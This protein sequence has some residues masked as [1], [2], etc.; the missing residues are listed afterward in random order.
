MRLREAQKIIRANMEDLDLE[1]Y[2]VNNYGSGNGTRIRISDFSRLSRAVNEISK[3]GFIDFELEA[4]KDNN[5]IL[6]SYTSEDVIEFDE[7]IYNKFKR[8]ID[9]IQRETVSLSI[10][11]RKHLPEQDKQSVTF[12]LPPYSKYSEIAYSFS[13]LKSIIDL[14]EIPQDEVEI[15]NFDTGSNWVEIFFIGISCLSFFGGALKLTVNGF[16]K[17][18]ECKLAKRKVDEAI[19]SSK[20]KEDLIHSIFTG[21]DNQ[22]KKEIQPE[23]ESY[24]ESQNQEINEERLNKTFA[25]V[26]KLFNLIDDGAK[27]E[28]AFNA[29]DKAKEDF[30]AA[31]AL[32][33]L[34][35]TIKKLTNMKYIET[36]DDSS[37]LSDEIPDEE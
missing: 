28:Q 18:Q 35:T 2:E 4:L 25:A 36:T 30:P 7:T 37:A 24:L 8:E 9:Y 29:T 16:L 31:N 34:P 33:I 26:Q 13:E 5:I 1:N 19:S 21:L 14:L 32:E 22:L 3:L 17:F 11:L 23:I 15:Q 6:N 27:F 20:S 10:F 12:G